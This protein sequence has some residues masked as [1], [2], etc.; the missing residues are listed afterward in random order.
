MWKCGSGNEHCV[1]RTEIGYTPFK[2]KRKQ[3]WYLKYS[4][5]DPEMNNISV[6]PKMAL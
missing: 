6:V 1:K 2:L 4:C 5:V 3:N